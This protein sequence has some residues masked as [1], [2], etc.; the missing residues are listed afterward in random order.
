[1]KISDR[2][3]SVGDFVKE[4]A[5]V[6]D[7]GAD[8]GLLEIYLLQKEKTKSLLAI[9][10]KSGPFSILKNNLKDYDVDILLSDGIKDMPPQVDTIVIA[11]MGGILITNILN[12]HEEKLTN[13]K[14]IVVDAHRD[15]ELVR[16]EITKLGFY[17]EKEK[18]IYENDVYYFVISFLKGHKDYSQ[19]QYEWGYK[20][21]EDPLFKQFKEAELKTLLMN[22]I[23][24]KSSEKSSL[25][26]IKEKEEKIRRLENYEHD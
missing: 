13:V 9:E 20:T 3:R 10:N 17:I 18:I 15:I 5:N 21:F 25:E 14:Q 4:G 23:R 1:M 2:L 26:A 11:G 12:A 8:H 7:V 16:R 6:I 22:L 19:E 24:F